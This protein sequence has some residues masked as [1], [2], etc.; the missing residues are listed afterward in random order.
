MLTCVNVVV[1]PLYGY[2]GVCDGITLL[3]FY[4]ASNATMHLKNKKYLS[5]EAITQ[6]VMLLLLQGS[7]SVTVL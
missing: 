3:I 6:V 7:I 1:D 5:Y 4:N 2:R